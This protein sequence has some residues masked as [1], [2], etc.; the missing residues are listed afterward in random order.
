MIF[1]QILSTNSFNKC[2]KIS[3]ENLYI[4]TWR[5][6]GLN[7]KYIKAWISLTDTLCYTLI[8]SEKVIEII[9][10][11]VF[12]WE[13]PSYKMGG[14][15]FSSCTN[16]PL[17]PSMH[18]QDISMCVKWD[19]V[20]NRSS[21]HLAAWDTVSKGICIRCIKLRDHKNEFCH[22]LYMKSLYQMYT[23]FIFRPTV[24]DGK[25]TVL[26]HQRLTN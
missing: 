11:Q 1:Y 19:S 17:A 26:F 24:K 3:L 16:H 22:L 12:P 8:E 20:L 2:I 14:F 10:A 6:T 21:E 5:V 23:L 13:G 25:Q 15:F 7:S 18:A 4:G 9:I